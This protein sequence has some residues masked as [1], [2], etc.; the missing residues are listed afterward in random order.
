MT[1]TEIHQEHIFLISSFWNEETGS[2]QFQCSFA[3]ILQ[4]ACIAASGDRLFAGLG[5]A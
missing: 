5:Q 3:L 4:A 1:A 2:D